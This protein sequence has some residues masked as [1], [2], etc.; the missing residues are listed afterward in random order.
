MPTLTV[1][2][3]ASGT[4]TDSNGSSLAGHMWLSIDSDGITGPSAP[5]SLGFA[6][7]ANSFGPLPLY[8]GSIHPDD[9]TIYR[10][11]YYTGTIAI[12]DIQYQQLKALTIDGVLEANGFSSFYTVGVNDCIAF[13]WKAL[14]IIGINVGQTGDL[15]PVDN[16]DNIDQ[17]LYSYL[18]GSTDGWQPDWPTQGNYNVTYGSSGDDNLKAGTSDIATITDVIYGGA[19]N[20][21]ITGIIADEYLYGG[22]G[23]DT[24]KGAGGNDI[25]EGGEGDDTY[26]YNQGDGFDTIS[27]DEGSI[28]ED[29]ATL[30]GGKQLG[31]NRVY[32]DT[33]SSSTKHTYVFVTGNNNIGGDLLVDGVILIR[34]FNNSDLGLTFN[35]AAPEQ[36]PQTGRAINGDLNPVDTDITQDGIQM[37]YDDLNNVVVTGEAAAGR[38]DTLNDSAG[39]DAI[40][41]GAGNDVVNAFRGGDDLIDAGAGQDQVYESNAVAGNDVISGGADNDILAGGLGDDRIYADQPISVAGAIAN[42]NSQD[43]TGN[44]GEWLAGE[45]GDDTLV[46]GVGNDALMGGGGNDL[47]ISGAGDDDIAGDANGVADTFAWT[48]T[49]V[50]NVRTFVPAIGEITPADSGADIIYAGKGNDNAWGGAGNDIVFGE[51]GDDHLEGDYGEGDGGNDLLFGGAGKDTQFGGKGDDVLAG[52]A[53]DDT[54]L[55]GAGKD[56]YLFNKGDGHDSVM[57]PD[58]DSTL[59][60]G[61]GITKNDITLKLGSLALDLG[62]GDEVHID[63]FDQNDVFNGSSVGSFTFADGSVLSLNDLLARGFDLNGTEFDDTVVGT[64]T[65]DRLSGL[66]GKYLIRT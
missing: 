63:G 21:S 57:D 46:S 20:D 53:D 22:D 59:I 1:K 12:S 45:S 18:L 49:W 27:D 36:T 35:A 31:D 24:L 16:A 29:G 43:G 3:A 62:H 37:A 42:G 56:T 55:G 65:T 17:L 34:N 23:D 51:D 26:I 13:V 33:D 9:D 60:F 32:Q 10:F 47:L 64:N 19:G 5:I 6:P 11:T 2:I 28:I 61:P 40:N 25:L 52:G 39:N 7:K 8:Q 41:S 44:K 14:Q 66:A 38:E 50:G 30:T 4:T 58:K 15:L 54:L 48:V